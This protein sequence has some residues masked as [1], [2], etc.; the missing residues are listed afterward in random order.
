MR[1]TSLVF[2]CP[3]CN[4]QLATNRVSKLKSI[5]REENPEDEP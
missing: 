2:V 1:P 5:Q 3:A 4:K